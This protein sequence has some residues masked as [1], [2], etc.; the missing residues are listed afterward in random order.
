[1]ECAVIRVF[2]SLGPDF[3]LFLVRTR[4]SEPARP[5][6]RYGARY[7]G[8]L[9]SIRIRQRSADTRNSKRPAK[10]FFKRPAIANGRDRGRWTF[11]G[12]LCEQPRYV[13]R[14]CSTSFIACRTPPGGTHGLPSRPAVHPTKHPTPRRRHLE[15]Y[16]VL[17]RRSS[18][19][20]FRTV[21]SLLFARSSTRSRSSTSSTGELH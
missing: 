3:S 14:G 4:R 17:E 20:V 19:I 2:E 15:P 16:S 8:R 21:F 18:Q 1:M 9:L 12:R 6:N 7:P 5:S 11:L 10:F 13:T